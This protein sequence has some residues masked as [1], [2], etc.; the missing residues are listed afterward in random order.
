MRLTKY[1][2]QSYINFSEEDSSAVIST[3]DS[4][5]KRR[6]LWLSEERPE[7]CSKVVN[8]N[9]YGEEYSFPKRWLRINPPRTISE[10]QKKR[11]VAN[12]HRE[13][14]IRP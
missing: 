14:H 4:I 8:G 1:E 6:L 10:K 13:S 3:F 5:L 11:Q 2:K 9:S 7:E 12:L